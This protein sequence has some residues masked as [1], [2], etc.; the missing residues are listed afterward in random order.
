M[1][2]RAIILL[3]LFFKIILGD[4][5]LH[6]QHTE[7]RYL[8]IFN[9][10]KH[11]KILYNQC[12]SIIEKKNCVT[13]LTSCVNQVYNN[14]IHG[15]NLAVDIILCIGSSSMFSVYNNIFLLLGFIVINIIIG[16]MV[17][18]VILF[19]N[20]KCVENLINYNVKNNTFSTKM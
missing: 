20:K 2:I 11:C 12:L 16:Y 7:N 15:T 18:F 9:N 4:N 14:N 1:S 6:C 13:E 19:I 10:I 17:F 8:D 3:V 5:N